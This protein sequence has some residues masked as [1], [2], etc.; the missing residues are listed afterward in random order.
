MIDVLG[1]L[2]GL[3]RTDAYLLCSVFADLR[4]SEVVI[5]P[6]WVVSLC[7]PKIIFK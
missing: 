5:H 3:D 2:H 6:N 7:F 1:D 4:I